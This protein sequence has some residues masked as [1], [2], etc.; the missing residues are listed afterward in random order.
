MRSGLDQGPGAEPRSGAGSGPSTAVK[1]PV[2][3][4]RGA[5]ATELSAA[6]DAR[7]FAHDGEIYL[8]ASHGSLTSGTGRS[9]L[10]H[11]LTHVAQ[12]RRLGASLPLEHTPHGQA[13]EA[14]ARGAERSPGMPLA[15]PAPPAHGP[16]AASGLESVPGGQRAPLGAPAPSGDNEATVHLSTVAQRAP[17]RAGDG[18]HTNGPKP[19]EPRE[20]TEQEL[21]ALAG[22][23]YA[24]IGRRLRRELLVDRERA[25]LA[26]DLG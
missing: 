4:H 14:E 12:Q 24:R 11:E 17:A 15:L 25:G 2:K 22:Q 6:L 10:A 26:L 23:L 9:L 5:A 13:L 20:R 16:R 18:Q 3:V 21:E 1:G 7:S 19:E 8:P